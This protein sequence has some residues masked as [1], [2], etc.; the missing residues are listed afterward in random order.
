MHPDPKNPQAK[1]AAPTGS[2]VPPNLPGAPDGKRVASRS[3]CLS[4]MGQAKETR[5]TLECKLSWQ[6]NLDVCESDQ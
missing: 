6:G 2:F 4:I 3:S 5:G 1:R